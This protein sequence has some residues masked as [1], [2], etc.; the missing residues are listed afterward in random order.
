MITFCL[1]NNDIAKKLLELGNKTGYN[2][3]QQHGQRIFG[4]PPPDWTG[5]NNLF[6]EVLCFVLLGGISKT[7]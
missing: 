7:D 5:M 4:G 1:D 6:E 3:L 2:I